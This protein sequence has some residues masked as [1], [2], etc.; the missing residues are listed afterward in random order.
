MRKNYSILQERVGEND[1]RTIE[2]NI[3]LKQFTSKAVQMQIETKKTQR[4]ITSQLSQV[5]LENLRNMQQTLKPGT[6]VLNGA[7]R[8]AMGSRD[9]SEV[10]NFING[11]TSSMPTLLH[12]NGFLHNTQK[13]KKKKKIQQKS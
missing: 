1:L 13:L 11:Q 6:T 2:S 9:L 3:W 8:I 5:K 12:G 10:L 7:S 4:D